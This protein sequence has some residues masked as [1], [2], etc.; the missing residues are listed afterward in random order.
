MEAKLP[1][2]KIDDAVSSHVSAAS[3]CDVILD[4]GSGYVRSGGIVK[5]MLRRNVGFWEKTGSSSFVLNTVRGGLFIPFESNPRRVVLKNNKSAELHAEFVSDSIAEM[6][7]DGYLEELNAVPFVVN[8]ITV[9][10]Q[11]CGKRRLICDLRHVNA[12]VAK[13][14][15]KMDDLR[16]VKNFLER[17]AF[18]TSFDIKKG[19]YHIEICEEHRD[20]SVSAG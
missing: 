11:A 12:Y 13:R 9:S 8:P 3:V 20:S 19:Y 15:F 10:V 16:T 6:L 17:E 7:A 2:R 14:K 18:L 5:G 4:K 1:R